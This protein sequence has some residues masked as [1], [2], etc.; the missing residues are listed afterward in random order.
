MTPF[1]TRLLSAI[2][3]VLT[4]I[5]LLYAFG[6]HG[7]RLLISVGVLIGAWELIGVLFKDLRSRS[8]R[9]LFY[10][11][12]VLMFAL[13]SYNL[14]LS[15][16]YFAC[17]AIAFSLMSLLIQRKFSSL[18]ELFSFQTKSIL[19]FFYIGLL[20]S[21]AMQ[22][23]NLPNGVAW[24]LTLLAVVFCGDT[25]AYLTG[26]FLGKTKLM[27]SISPKKT[28]EGAAGG[29]VASVIAGIVAAQYVDQPALPMAVLALF[30]GMIAQFGDLF[31]SLLKRVADI[32]DSGQIMP[33]HGGILDRI[34]G[35]LFASPIMLLGAYALSHFFH[36]I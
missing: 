34:D 10:A 4:I 14:A 30:T 16:V 21:F 27:P 24:F 12:A 7:M 17:I 8:S 2:G 3:A 36:L 15:G 35:V 28:I 26:M 23:V 25:G 22:L 13:S 5:G 6:S 11:L 18:D 31:E 1:Q 19:G 29:L 33:G 9:V 20:P 32:K